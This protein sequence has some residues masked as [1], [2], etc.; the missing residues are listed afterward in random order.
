MARARS[1]Q[2]QMYPGMYGASRS[3]TS[4]DVTPTDLDNQA[5]TLKAYQQL[6]Q[7]HR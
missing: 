5:N 6:V 2:Q 3:R 7:A 4:G 1:H